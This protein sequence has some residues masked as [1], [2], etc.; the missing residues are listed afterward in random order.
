ML[1]S[2][3]AGV[4][5][6]CCKPCVGITAAFRRRPGRP[7]CLPPFRSTSHCR[8]VSAGSRET[9]PGGSSRAPG[10]PAAWMHP[11]ES[12]SRRPSRRIRR[13]SRCRAGCPACPPRRKNRSHF[14]YIRSGMF[15]HCLRIY[16]SA[17][18]GGQKK[19][20]ILSSLHVMGDFDIQQS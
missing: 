4:A 6:R 10:R 19:G 3:L 7:S 5:R 12:P 2:F 1:A 11:C 13:R 15:F 9:T 20:A 17:R 14:R 18:R 16:A 8:Q